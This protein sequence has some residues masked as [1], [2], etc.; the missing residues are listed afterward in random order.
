MVV[1][2]RHDQIQR[3]RNEAQRWVAVGIV[4]PEQ[5][6]AIVRLE[7]GDG[8]GAPA[9]E[10]HVPAPRDRLPLIAELISYLGIILVSAS[11][12][13][14]IRRFWADLHVGGRLAV[15]VGVAAVGLV[16]G[17][18]VSRLGDPGARRLGS[19]LW[20]CGTAGVG[21]VAGVAADTAGN[22]DQ[23]TTVLCAGLAVLG[24]SVALW[25]N[26]DR[27]LQFL[28]TLV[29]A[30]MVTVGLGLVMHVSLT[31]LEAGVIVWCAAVVLALL[32]WRRVLHPG[33]TVLI[34]GELGTLWGAVT[35]A[36]SYT[37]FGLSLGAS[38]AAAGVGLGLTL[39]RLPLVV[40]GILGFLGFLGGILGRYLHG[41]TAALGV[42][43]VGIVLVF[44]AIRYGM[45]GRRAAVH[46]PA[47]REDQPGVPTPS[48]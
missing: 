39:K 6:D 23:H 12:A 30:V 24:V 27:P 15:G 40:V 3:L 44:L 10:W 1:D 46:E 5:A 38:S 21:L 36:N 33:P 48:P 43:V 31:A 34:V 20:L 2:S 14:I 7:A 28:S 29:G 18:V 42:F 22:H 45:G 8:G 32:G 4:S 16:G 17:A 26:L 25:R 35:I 37:A 9:P 41:P 13:L 47:Q 19:F 11:G